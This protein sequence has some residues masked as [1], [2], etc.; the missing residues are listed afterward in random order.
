MS[1]KNVMH[2]DPSQQEVQAEG[3]MTSCLCRGFSTD[4]APWEVAL[5]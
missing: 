1:F 3:I 4:V 5:H 2:V